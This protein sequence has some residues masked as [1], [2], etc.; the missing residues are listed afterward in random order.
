MKLGHQLVDVWRQGE[1]PIDVV[2]VSVESAFL[3]DLFD[4]RGQ[5]VVV[6]GDAERD[7]EIAVVADLSSFEGDA[8]AERANV[9]VLVGL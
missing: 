3:T 1:A 7:G 2:L 9:L 6:V 8:G 5:F 4:L